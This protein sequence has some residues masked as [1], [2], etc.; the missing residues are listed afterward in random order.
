M[1]L[2]FWGVAVFSLIFGVFLVVNVL[3][4]VCFFYQILWAL[5]Q[6]IKAVLWPLTQDFDQLEVII[7][8]S[9]DCNVHLLSSLYRSLLLIAG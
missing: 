8:K 2:Q 1:R 9:F 5:T 6:G 3:D 7:K 4:F